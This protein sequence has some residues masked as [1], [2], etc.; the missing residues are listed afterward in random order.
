MIDILKL[1]IPIG[2]AIF[3]EMA[4]FAVVSFLIAALGV[5]PMAAHSIAGN[6]NWLTYVIPMGMGSA[7]GIRVAFLVGSGD[8]L[9]ARVTAGAV[10]KF[11]IGYAVIV[12]VL[13]ILFR[14]SLVQVYTTDV[15][16]IQLAASLLVLIAV[17]Q[18]VDDTQ[19][20]M[21]GSLRGYKDTTMPMVFSLVGFWILAL[22]LGYLLATG[23]MTAE[24]LGVFGYWLGITAGLAIVAVMMSIRLRGLSADP[25]K[26]RRFSM[27][28]A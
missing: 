13:L 22:P 23:A 25:D 2:V 26:I 10:V 6:L 17:Y 20:V 9:A 4:M 5:V 18:L 3:L 27:R 24:P 1:G 11:A 16:V 28:G 19:A 14:I 15:E 21:I 7:A 12:S 8:L